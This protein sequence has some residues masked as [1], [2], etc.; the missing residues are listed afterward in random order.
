[1]R[2]IWYR[3]RCL[4][5]VRWARA[6]ALACVVAVVGGLVLTLAAGAYRT[7]GA[8]DRYS[9]Q[10][11]KAYDASLEQASGP[12]RTAEVEALPAVAGVNTAT[13]V[14][15]GLVGP[16]GDPVESLIFAGS[17]TAFGAR[18]TGGREPERSAPGEFV[19]TS[20]WVSLT[21]AQLGDSFTVVTIT[22]EQADE[23]GFD[24]AEPEGPTLPATL[25]GVI[26]GPSDL[27]EPTPTALFPP[28]L[29][30]VGDVGVATTVGVVSLESGSTLDDLRSQLDAL[31]GGEV[32]GLDTAEWVPADVRSAVSTQ[33]LG[34][35]VVAAIVAIAA[36]A[37]VG[38]LLSRQVRLPE[39]VRLAMSSI[40]LTRGQLVAD[41]LSTTAVPILVGSV[42]A[43]GLAF[44]ASGIFPVGFSRRIE[45]SPGALFEPL[46]HGLGALLL[47][48]ALVTWVVVALV[49]GERRGQGEHLPGV[50]QRLVS[51]IRPGPAAT[52]TRFALTRHPRDPGSPRGPI[53]GLALVLGVLVGALVFG[54][55]LGRFIDEPASYGSNFDLGLGQGG[56]EVPQEVR[57]LLEQDPDVTA[58]TLYGTV[59]ASVGT[60]SLDVTGMQPLRGDLRPDLLSGVLPRGAEEIVL[61]RVDAR[62]VGAEVGDDL[63]VAGAAG[64]VT[65][66]VTGLAVI[67]SVEGG[68][69]IGEGGVVTLEG[70]RR[71]DPDATLGAAA[72]RLRPGATTDVVQRLT[73]ETGVTAAPFDPPSTV[74][75]LARVRSTPFL[76][77]IALGAL[78]VLSLAHQL[79]LS[80]R[81][82]R[83]DLAVLRALGA[84]R[85]WVTGVLHWQVTVLA[86]AVVVL[87]APLGIAAGRIV[88]QAFIDRIGAG[89]GTS[90]PFALLGAILVALLVL[91][92]LAA[93]VPARQARHEHPTRI[94]ADE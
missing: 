40:G 12:P 23:G 87:A 82:R 39:A 62:R 28:S 18:V 6:V 81:R 56:D 78:G 9:A 21:G 30:E 26:E 7:V 5:R 13:F 57:S 36:I 47:A 74:L 71:I 83:R 88:Y 59:L 16:G 20:S 50:A 2:P 61:G 55:S 34:F 3:L 77:A 80:A 52:G 8:P 58:A 15:G 35:A 64:P 60:K 38:Q 94:L 51:R 66:H 75:N 4:L 45:V 49:L 84:D 85:R 79:I 31:P 72:V 48:L 63:V 46:V 70:L 11:G 37:V 91:G 33:G 65:F 93:V 1:M 14:F 44:A 89:Y 19:A 69:G 73:G 24:V 76:V 25:V 17:Y 90:I 10:Q 41:P 43:A 67:P 29:L 27:Q 42:L 54:A 53:I 68:D 32:F 22:Q 86:S 92:N